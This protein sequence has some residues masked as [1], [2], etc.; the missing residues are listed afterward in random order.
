MSW[1]GLD[2]A[3]L[4]EDAASHFF[5]F[6]FDFFMTGAALAAAFNNFL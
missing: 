6:L 5:A 2:Y 4:A 1:P 3:H